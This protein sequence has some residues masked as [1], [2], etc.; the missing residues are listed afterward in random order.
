MR[1]PRRATPTAFLNARELATAHLS[2]QPS[3]ST[4]IEP[5]ALR[6]WVQLLE[7]CS[8]HE[9]LPPHARGEMLALLRERK[10]ARHLRRLVGRARMLL[11][12]PRG[13]RRRRGRLV[14]TVYPPRPEQPPRANAPLMH[15]S[16]LSLYRPRDLAELTRASYLALQFNQRLHWTA[17]LTAIHLIADRPHQLWQ[18]L[19]SL[20]A[21]ARERGR[22]ELL[23]QLAG[24][25]AVLR[26]G[27]QFKAF[28]PVP[29]VTLSLEREQPAN[30]AP[31]GACR[32]P[33]RAAAASI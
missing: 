10:N 32:R 21:S 30:G 12:P 33:S 31:A 17:L 14:L 7:R 9:G 23:A 27:S 15:R 11:A 8:T 5:H 16:G 6:V 22:Q 18:V 4:G 1:R 2:D 29:M 25:D 19:S 24:P 3:A 13:G 28:A 26:V 20:L